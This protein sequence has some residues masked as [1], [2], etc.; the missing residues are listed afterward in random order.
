MKLKQTTLAAMA[1]AGMAGISGTAAAFDLGNCGTTGLGTSG[2]ACP[3]VTYG[4]A[5][6]YSLNL[7]AYLW[8]VFNGGVYTSPT[9]PFHVQSGPGQIDDLIVIATGASGMPVLTNFADMDNAYPTPNGVSGSTFFSTGGVADPIPTGAWDSANTWDTSVAALQ[10]FLGAGN[11]PVFF[12]NNNQV[13][14]GAS[15]NQNLAVWAQISLTD[16]A[17]SKVYF[18]FTNLGG[19]YTDPTSFAGSGGVFNGDPTAYASTGVGPLAGDNKNTDYVLAGGV[20][21][22]DNATLGP[23]A[24]TAGTCPTGSTLINNNLGADQAAYALVFPELNAALATG[25]WV[26][27]S[28]DL[29]FGC[30]PATLVP[31]T[32]CVGRDA[33]NG[34]EQLFIGS[35]AGTTSVPEPGSLALMGLGLLGLAVSLRRRTGKLA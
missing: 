8:S 27:M 19:T 20:L 34:Y 28:V 35:L 5:N 7:N 31:G 24:S 23:V 10:T 17:G 33:N 30:D 4:D 2:T 26:S 16:A 13:N 12:F 14:S 21:C 22:V 3:Y 18:D 9:N 15:T 1:F 32:N 29:R 6:S 11:T 25:S